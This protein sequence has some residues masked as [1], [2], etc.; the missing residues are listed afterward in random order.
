[1]ITLMAPAAPPLPGTTP[2]APAAGT[3]PWRS[4]RARGM[5]V[6]DLRGALAGVPDWAI[7]QIPLPDTFF[8]GRW[9][10][11]DVAEAGYG[12]GV[13]TLEPN[14]VSLDI[15]SARMTVGE[16]RAAVA[17]VPGWAVTKI[18]VEQ[19]DTTVVADLAAAD[20]SRG[21]LRLVTA[22]TEGAA[23]GYAG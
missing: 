16:L 7:V 1:M 2:A 5:T 21:V 3:T 17:D 19:D 12:R 10:G 18:P 23:D 15:P 13:L 9:W 8:E 11:A 20:Y 14:V 6:D 22:D 4:R